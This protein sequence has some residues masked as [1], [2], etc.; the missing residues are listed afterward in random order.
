MIIFR[1][2]FLAAGS[3]A[4]AQSDNELDLGLSRDFGYGGFG[5]DIQGLFTIK[6]KNAPAN[7]VRVEFFVDTTSMGADTQAPFSL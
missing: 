5:N 2:W 3:I 1:L 6:V 7:L 4:V